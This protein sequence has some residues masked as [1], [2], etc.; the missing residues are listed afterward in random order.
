M[1]MR[2]GFGPRTKVLAL[3]ATVALAA[4]D[5]DDP[6]G[7]DP[8]EVESIEVVAGEAT[9]VTVVGQA[10]TGTVEVALD[11]E[12]EIEVIAFDGDDEELDLDGYELVV[13]IDDETVASFELAEGTFSGIV[14]GLAEGTTTVVIRIVPDGGGDDL[15]TSPEIDLVVE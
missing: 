3:L 5:D 14:E 8:L 11:G 9:L 7:P 15:Y 12:I 4:C 10:V 1:M 6:T 2:L 13:E